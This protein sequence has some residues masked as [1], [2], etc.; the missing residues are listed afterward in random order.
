MYSF[1]RWRNGIEIKNNWVKKAGA[2]V[3]GGGLSGFRFFLREAMFVGDL[4]LFHFFFSSGWWRFLGSFLFLF[5]SFSFPYGG[6]SFIELIKL[7]FFLFLGS[8]FWD[9]CLVPTGF[10][11]IPIFTPFHPACLIVSIIVSSDSHS[12]SYIFYH[13]PFFS[14]SSLSV[15]CQNISFILVFSSAVFLTHYIIFVFCR[16]VGTL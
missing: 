9:M 2:Y 4:I 15:P 1:K 5:L 12:R 16:L 7:S 8:N 10:S 6:I 3:F 13:L 11:S 14:F